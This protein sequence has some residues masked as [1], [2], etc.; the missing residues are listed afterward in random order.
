MLGQ[1]L[2]S[3]V[4][5][6]G[7]VGA[8]ATRVLSYP[9]SRPQRA[10]Y[11]KKEQSC[12]CTCPAEC[13]LQ[14]KARVEASVCDLYPQK[15]SPEGSPEGFKGSTEGSKEGFYTG[16]PYGPQEE[17]IVS[18]NSLGEC[19]CSPHVQVPQP[20]FPKKGFRLR[21]PKKSTFGPQQ[22]S[23]ASTSLS[24][25]SSDP[26]PPAEARCPVF[27][28][29]HVTSI[30]CQVG[31]RAARECASVVSV[32][33]EQTCHVGCVEFV[34]L[35]GEEVD[36]RFVVVDQPEQVVQHQQSRHVEVVLGLRWASRLVVLMV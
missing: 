34:E 35:V 7:W 20:G 19:M 9:K 31:P 17:G 2:L 3:C 28:R 21:S 26:Q 33:P 24:T 14:C 11:N 36:S 5:R 18:P 12:P 1:G 27:R 16:I 30:F 23:L 4:G 29:H 25:L 32:L 8:V 22:R 15:G 6:A 10:R 13:V